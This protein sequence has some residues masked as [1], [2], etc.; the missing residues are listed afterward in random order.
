MAAFLHSLSFAADNF[1][2]A[3]LPH[4]YV[5]A[6]CAIVP[7]VKLARDIIEEFMMVAHGYATKYQPVPYGQPVPP[8]C[9]PNEDKFKEW[10]HI[11]VDWATELARYQSPTYRAILVAPMERDEEDEGI[12]YIHTIEQVRE[13]LILRGIPPDQ[14]AKAIARKTI[15][16]ESKKE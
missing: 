16:H 6:L 10:A 9:K 14:F 4:I 1:C 3:R 8:G 7:K 15:E 2:L 5:E 12:E 11:T 13:Q